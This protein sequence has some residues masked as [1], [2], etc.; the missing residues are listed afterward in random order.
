MK[1]KSAS[2]KDLDTSTAA[3]KP[4]EGAVWI[5]MEFDEDE[6]AATDR[7]TFWKVEVTELTLTNMDSD[8]VVTE[9]AT[10]VFGSEVACVDHEVTATSALDRYVGDQ[11]R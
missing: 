8:E 9:D 11:Q 2:G 10:Q 4:E 5:V 1:F 6:H 3:D 7:P